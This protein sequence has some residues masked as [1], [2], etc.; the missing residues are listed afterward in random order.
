MVIMRLWKRKVLINI[1]PTT[2]IQ[3]KRKKM[4]AAMDSI[5]KIQS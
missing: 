1:I 2:K 5:E 3:R 4:E